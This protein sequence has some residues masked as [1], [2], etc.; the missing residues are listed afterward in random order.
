MLRSL[1]VRVLLLAFAA[2]QTTTARASAAEMAQVLTAEREAWDARSDL[3]G[4]EAAAMAQMAQEMPALQACIVAVTQQMRGTLAAYNNC[5]TGPCS[6]HW[7]H[8][9]RGAVARLES[10]LQR[11][12]L[13]QHMMHAMLKS[14]RKGPPYQED[15]RSTYEQL[16]LGHDA[17]GCAQDAIADVLAGYSAALLHADAWSSGT[18]LGADDAEHHVTV[19]QAKTQKLLYT[20]HAPRSA[21]LMLLSVRAAPQGAASSG[22]FVPLDDVVRHACDVDMAAHDVHRTQLVCGLAK[23]VGLSETCANEAESLCDA[24]NDTWA[25]EQQVVRLFEQCGGGVK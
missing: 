10:S 18:T 7:R 16:M 22:A 11:C 1:T 8:E 24:D 17:L 6:A 19:I 9:A 5:L 21:R 4:E 13:N 20:W 2:G 3:L 23:Q 14:K 25:D 12:Q 15:T